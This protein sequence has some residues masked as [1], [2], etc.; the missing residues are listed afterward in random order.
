MAAVSRV[1]SSRQPPIPLKEQA[2]YEDFTTCR[3]Y[4]EWVNGTDKLKR[5]ADTLYSPDASNKELLLRCFHEY[6]ANCANDL[7]HLSNGERHTRAREILGG[8]LKARWTQVV[9][10]STAATPPTV[11]DADFAANVRTFMRNY[12]PAN[13][14]LLQD[15][16]LRA[17][18]KPYAMDC[19]ALAD[20]IDLIN[21][22]SIYLPG[23]NGSKL[24]GD[25][26]DDTERKNA[27][28]RLM[29]PN[30]QLN[31]DATGHDLADAAY[32]IGKLVAFM[33]QQRLLQDNRRV[34]GPGGRA[35]NRRQQRRS[36]PYP[37][38]PSNR[39]YENQY[40]RPQFRNQRYP[41]LQPAE[42]GAS[43]GRGNCQ[44]RGGRGGRGNQTGRGR[45]RN[46]GTQTYTRDRYQTCSMG[47]PHTSFQ[48]NKGNRDLFYQDPS[49]VQYGGRHGEPQYDGFYQNQEE[50][51]YYPPEEQAYFQGDDQNHHA[52]EYPDD[53]NNHYDGFYG[54]H[55]GYD[56]DDQ[57][58]QD[59]FHDHDPQAQADY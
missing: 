24:F 2:S 42:R 28:Y 36:A 20:R 11:G 5:S 23:G 17:A 45:N 46:A 3:I 47:A 50:D 56:Q 55:D 12:L 21:E 30:W 19:Y 13:A 27:Y 1:Q 37:R 51:N 48:R 52:D 43:A 18:T 39:G 9:A 44:Q 32:T 16:Y 33:E 4:H 40:S 34:A 49:E 14:F 35:P 7:L 22:L 6:V 29:P 41:A 59:F 57:Y 8:H 58:P 31:F 10:S 38:G 26:T 53:A 15:T 54:E 25:G